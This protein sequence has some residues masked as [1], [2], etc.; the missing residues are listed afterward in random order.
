[1]SKIIKAAELKVLI[2]N[3][4]QTII[5]SVHPTETESPP[6]EGTILD[7]SNLLKDAQKKAKAL[8]SQAKDEAEQLLA[9]A[10]EEMEALHLRA[11][12]EGYQRGQK[13]GQEAGRQEV[14]TESLALIELLEQTV[15][16]AV[17]IRASSLA[18]LEDDF[19]KLSLLLADKIVRKTVKD[20]LAWLAPIIKD[21]LDSLGTVEKIMVHL[22]PVD[23]AVVSGNAGDLNLHTR[24]RLQFESDPAIAQGGCLIEAE[25]GRI[26]ARLEKRLGK[27]AQRLMEVLYDERS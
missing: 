12:E 16:E 18:A 24:T 17:Q 27:I 4:E 9:A 20:D 21:A 7:G 6:T 15:E 2:P 1:M 22:N 13:E 19:L 8:I 14:L 11:Q 25:N 10:K 5:R 26:D 23:Y 3:E